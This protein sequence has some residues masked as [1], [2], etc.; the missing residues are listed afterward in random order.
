[1]SDDF[2]VLAARRQR[3]EAAGSTGPYGFRIGKK[4]YTWPEELPAASIELIGELKAVTDDKSPEAMAAATALVRIL[5]GDQADELLQALSI[6]DLVVMMPVYLEKVAG[7]GLG[8]S[9]GSP[10]SSPDT[11]KRPRQTS[12]RT[13]ASSSATTTAGA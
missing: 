2:D 13:T 3:A 8:E 4:R 10:E 5:S 1:M 11:P 6:N 7:S 12:R 9:S